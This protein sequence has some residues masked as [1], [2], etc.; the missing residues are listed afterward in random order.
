MATNDRKKIT[1]QKKKGARPAS[2][3]NANQNTSDQSIDESTEATRNSPETSALYI[4]ATPIGHMGDMTERA[5]QVL[6]FV[7]VIL[8][9]DTRV[10]GML[11]KRFGLSSSL[12]AYHEHNADRVRPHILKRLQQGQRVALVSD[13]GTPLISD[14]GYKLVYDVLE[15]GT[16][17]IPV[18]GACAVITALMGAGQPTD[19]FLFSGFLPTRHKA[20][21]DL[22]RTLVSVKATLIFYES[23]HRLVE[24]LTD[25]NAIFGPRPATVCRELTKLHEEIQRDTLD[26]LATRYASHPILKGEVVVVVAPPAEQLE[27]KCSVDIDHLLEHALRYLSV[28]DAAALVSEQSGAKKNQV[29][30]RALVL[31][32]EC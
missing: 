8:C 7:D 20:R 10:T 12:I 14:P 6:A 15:H 17:V 30:A 18:P 2:G 19:R 1:Q 29:Y 21:C 4:V 27:E 23:V 5:C 22:L 31:G 32:R 16:R 11:L 24:S 28:R 3:K 25:M 13:A 9:E 26:V